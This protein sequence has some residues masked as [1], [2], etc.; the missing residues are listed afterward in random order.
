MRRNLLLSHGRCA[1]LLACKCLEKPVV[2]D[3]KIQHLV[4]DQQRKR[5][6]VENYMDSVVREPDDELV[7]ANDACVN[8]VSVEEA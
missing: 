8:I 4:T 5:K 7:G 1:V 6:T 3:T 2:R